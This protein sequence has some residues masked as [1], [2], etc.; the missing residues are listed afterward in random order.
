[1]QNHHVDILLPYWGDF[2]LLTKAVDSVL[3]QTS[4]D[5]HLYILD[6]C[7]P[8]KQAERYYTTNPHQK[9]TYIRHRENIGITKNFNFALSKSTAEFCILL[10]CDDILLPAYIETALK[11]I[12]TADIYQPSVDVIDANG[13]T[14]LPLGDRVKRW[15]QPKKS[16]MLQGEKLVTS[17]CYG[18]WLYFPS[19]LW[20]TQT[21][22]KYGFNEQYTI[23]ED[24]QLE[25]EILS[26]G[27]TLFFDKQT[28]F[29]YRRFAN[30]LSS[31]EKS[32]NGVRFSEEKDIYTRYAAFFK[33]IGW[34]RA[35]LAAKIRI[36]SRLNN[37]IS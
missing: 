26:N 37:L 36:T 8:D 13:K 28:T 21:I 23:V 2:T 35:S 29:Q 15:L 20:R 19:L 24:V 16:G 11:K 32:K 10:G 5:W 17:L 27:G 1:M 4:D 33:K 12:G 3:S 34:R 25:F 9:I 14:Y 30:S 7:Y 22:K 6:D 31:R 18:N